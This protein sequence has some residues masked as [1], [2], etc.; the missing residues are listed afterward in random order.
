VLLLALDTSAAVTAAVHDGTRV[1]AGESVHDPR[2][3]AELLV[4]MVDRVLVA[5]G[6]HRSDLTDVVAGRGPGPFTGLRVGLVTART[7]GL[8]LG[9]PVHG[10]GSLDALGQQVVDA[11][12]AD[13]GE[14]FVVATDA[15]R[16]EVY[17]ARY[18]HRDG[19]AHPL[20]E[21]RVDRPHDVPLDGL[22]VHGRGAVLHAD[23][24]GSPVDGP[25]DPDARALA[26]VAA[27][28]LAA[29]DDLSSTAPLY[30]RRPDATP[31]GAGKSVLGR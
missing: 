2:H 22:R 1:L 5:A 20:D 28:R 18:E 13:P 12:G 11:G 15:R 14:T 8:A 17:W 19:V 21:P 10:V 25:L 30:L 6:A 4:P 7:L 31:P 29:G 24:L 26:A 16:R 27:R 3:H 23:A 9:V